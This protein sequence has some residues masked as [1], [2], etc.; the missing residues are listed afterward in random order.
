MPEDTPA[1]PSSPL[2]SVIGWIGRAA[3]WL[4]IP[5]VVAQFVLVILRYAFGVGSIGAQEAIIYAHGTV[6]MLGA[7]LVLRDDRQ[8]RVDVLYRLAG[9]RARSIINLTGHVVVLIPLCVIVANLSW[10][11]V[12]SSWAIYESSRETSGLPGVFLHKTLLLAFS[13]LLGLQS[14]SLVLAEIRRLLR[15][16]TP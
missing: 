3:G 11:Y 7:A 12:A 15:G 4:I 14:L 16:R 9:W 5:M 6:F 1:L 13:V 2:D 10:P 8:V